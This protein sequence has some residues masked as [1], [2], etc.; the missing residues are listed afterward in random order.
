M[1]N[2]GEQPPRAWAGLRS[3]HRQGGRRRFVGFQLGPKPAETSIQPVVSVQPGS[4]AV[5]FGTDAVVSFDLEGRLYVA[6]LNGRT[7]RRGL[8][9]VVL[10]KGRTPET[11]ERWCR[12]LD[13]A[14]RWA[15]YRAIQALIRKALDSL[16]R[17]EA[18]VAGPGAPRAQILLERAGAWSPERLERERLRFRAVYGRVGIIPPDQYLAVVV[19]ATRGCAWNRCTFCTFYR[20][21]RFFVR[22]PEEFRAHCRAVR[23]FLGEG[24]RLRRSVF[25]AEARALSVPHPRLRRFLEIAREEFPAQRTLHAF[26]DLFTARRTEEEL[27]ELASLGL[28][29]V[30]IGLETGCDPLLALVQKPT[31]AA[32]ALAT[33]RTLKAAG[34]SVA[35]VVLLGLG[36]VTWAGAHLR[37]T[38]AL[39][40]AMELGPGDLIYVSPLVV[41]PASAYA[42]QCV[43]H[44]FR[45]LTP[46]ELRQQ[47][48]QLRAGLGV[49]AGRPRVARYDVRE[50]V[51]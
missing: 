7:F 21:D 26:M 34:L 36:G 43:T 5:A 39:L 44:G 14:E 41:D 40:R 28:R 27:R 38:L 35:L 11:G 25:L 4:F 42:R 22:S 16:R 13:T 31:T 49:G 32:R 9:G 19:Q 12:P 3:A 30:V 50:L 20:G 17:G 29:R 1:S 47:E 10:E 15:L 48:A 37:D 6:Y 24:L 8:S 18:R 23:E 51:Y 46:E 45:S 2:R 33:V